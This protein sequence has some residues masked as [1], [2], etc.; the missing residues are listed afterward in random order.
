[1][2]AIRRALAEGWFREQDTAVVLY[3]LDALLDRGEALRGAFPAETLHAFAVKACPLPVVLALLA[4]QGFG[5][6]A[7]SLGEIHLALAAGFPPERIVFDSPAK[8]VEELRL[9]LELQCIAQGFRFSDPPP[10]EDCRSRLT[11]CAARQSN[12]YVARTPDQASSRRNNLGQHFAGDDFFKGVGREGVRA[13][14]VDDMDVPSLTLGATFLLFHSDSR[15][16][17]HFQISSCIRI[18]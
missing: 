6:E 17:C 15:P 5:A 18:E 1:M 10:H 13:G 16:I 14:E 12:G 11:P 2:E 3:D 9:A 7:A 8:T 4:E